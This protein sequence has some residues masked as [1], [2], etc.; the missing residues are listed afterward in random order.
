[1][2]VLVTGGSGGVGGH[3]VT[4]LLKKGYAVVVFDKRADDVAP[5]VELAQGDICDPDSMG[6]ALEGVDAVLHLAAILPPVSEQ[7]VGLSEAVNVEG[8][9]VI[10]RAMVESPS[11]R[12]LIFTSTTAVHGSRPDRHYPIRENEPLDPPDNYARQ[13]I[14]AEEAIRASSLDWTILRIP[15]VPPTRI[16]KGPSGGLKLFLTI[17]PDSRIEILHPDD[18]AT[19]FA[20]C[21]ECEATFH[22]TLF[23]GGGKKNGCQLTGYEMSCGMARAFG[24]G[25]LP[26]HIFNTDPGGAH[27]EWLDTAESQA[28]L[29]YQTRSFDALVDDMRKNLG[30][31]YYVSRAVSPITRFVITKFLAHS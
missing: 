25:Q 19:A 28:L 24:I 14:A 2:K 29:K 13:K 21:V 6:N 9:K 26:R 27:A 31:V 16:Q 7:N 1:M 30:L 10:I 17:P 5:G 15:A 4:A 23:L 18:A 22:R 12:R 8:T 20:N 11:C 3:A